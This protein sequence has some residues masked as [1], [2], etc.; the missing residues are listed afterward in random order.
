MEQLIQLPIDL[1]RTC[2]FHKTLKPAHLKSFMF[3][4]HTFPDRFV[5]TNDFYKQWAIASGV[6]EKTTR[7]HFKALLKANWIGFNKATRRVFVRSKYKLISPEHAKTSRY[8]LVKLK[9]L[10]S[11][12]EVM[13]AAMITALVKR[14]NRLHKHQTPELENGGSL[15]ASGLVRR[16]VSGHAPIAVN[17]LARTMNRSSSW[18]DRVKQKALKKGLIEK[19]SD[20][21]DT[22][23]IWAERLSF[24]K[25]HEGVCLGRGRKVNGRLCLVGIDLLSSKRLTLRK[26]KG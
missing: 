6:T 5:I 8:V 24:Y 15:Q 19:V 22:N 7:S 25:A 4:K 18:I 13:L 9:D 10:K 1:C 23:T 14:Y 16:F 21:I 2:L 12:N 26:K 11:I 17:Y 20:L 3:L